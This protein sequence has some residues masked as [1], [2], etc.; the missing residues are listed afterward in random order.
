MD[1]KKSVAFFIVGMAL[2][3][4]MVACVS[5]RAKI[6]TEK[7]LTISD[8]AENW[9]KYDVYYAGSPGRPIGILF[10]PKNDDVKLVGDQWRKVEDE[11]TL[12][13]VIAAVSPGS[14]PSS[15]TSRSNGQVIGYYSS[16]KYT[17]TTQYYGGHTYNPLAKDID[18]NTY[19]VELVRYNYPERNY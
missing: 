7:A 12:S 9:K 14:N 8:L 2:M 19:K 17:S 4:L 16:T 6:R 10:D 5:S 15:I 1:R 3:S 18:A 11:G 13:S